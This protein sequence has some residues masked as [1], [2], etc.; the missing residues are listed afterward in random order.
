MADEQPKYVEIADDLAARIR[1]GEWGPGDQLPGQAAL[2]EEQQVGVQTV[3]RAFEL[4]QN[5]GL[6]V[7]ES[8]RGSFVAQPTRIHDAASADW[9]RR[10]QEE[11]FGEDRA[12]WE[13]LDAGMS[14]PDEVPD[15]VRE[16]LALDAEEGAVWRD[17]RVL[18][19][20]VPAQWHRAWWPGR[21]GDECPELGDPAPVTPDT[22][23]VIEEATGRWTARGR[24]RV[25]SRGAS[26]KDAEL[27]PVE[28]GAPVLE[29]WRATWDQYGDPLMV[30]IDVYPGLLWARQDP[31][32]TDRF[33]AQKGSEESQ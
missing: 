30:E 33:T 7:T 11:R 25:R 24:D 22:D 23:A 8:R 1:R 3:S 13:T 20:G 21:V 6:V 32:E 27:L 12:R 14:E 17:R 10:S 15:E 4:L 2:A 16:A 5:E 31:Y 18:D 28:R 29:M 19:A 9:H 26:T